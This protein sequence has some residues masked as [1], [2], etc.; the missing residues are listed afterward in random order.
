[1]LYEIIR[2]FFFIFMAEMGDKTQLLAMAFA[3]KYPL[4][5][6]LVGVLIG[7]LL[8]HGIAVVLGNYLTQFIPI[9]AIQL[10]AAIAFIVFGLWTLKIEEEEEENATNRGFGPIMTVAMAFFIGEL[11]DKTQLT[12]ITLSTSANYP[13]CIL[14]GTVTGM[15]F[16]S[17]IGIIIGSRLGKRIPEIALKLGAAMIFLIFGVMGLKDTI[18]AQY[19]NYYSVTIFFMFLILIV[20]VLVNRALGI[21]RRKETPYKR[22]ASQLY[23]NTQRITRSLDNITFSNIEDKACLKAQ[24]AIE[25]LKRLLQ[26]AHAKEAYLVEGEW[27]IPCCQINKQEITGLKESLVETLEVCLQCS[28]HQQNCV[29]N[30]TRK[31][32]ENMVFGENLPYEGNREKYYNEIKKRDPNFFTDL[33]VNS[34]K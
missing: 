26:E 21:S 23:I 15:V 13:L 4:K 33:E 16:T 7:S 5:K 28:D 12:A 30:Q 22:A 18:P 2:G 25:L 17:A 9:D 34:L 29:G 20:A 3:A 8:N 1:M 32:L 31:I 27:E 10:I 11:G 14:L 19:I 6:V 24:G